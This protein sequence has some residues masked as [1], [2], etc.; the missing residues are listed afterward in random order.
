[1]PN[2]RKQ[3]LIWVSVYLF[4]LISLLTPLGILTISMMTIPVIVLFMIMRI[5][6]FIIYQL[7]M[8][9]VLLIFTVAWPPGIF[10]TLISLY[11][12]IGASAMG[13]FY[14][15][16][17][18][19]ASVIAIGT[20][21]FLGELLL[22]L[23]ISAGLGLNLIEQYSALIKQSLESTQPLWNVSNSATEMEQMAATMAQMVPMFMIIFALFYA[24]I[25]HAI[26]RKLLSR[27]E[28]A[29]PALKPFKDWMIPKSW[30]WF[31]VAALLLEVLLPMDP[32]SVL[33]VILLNL[34]P[35]LML[36]FSIQGLSFLYYVS[37]AKG[38]GHVL[39]AV[40][41]VLFVFLSYF[42]SFL[43]IIDT[44]FNLRGRIKK[45]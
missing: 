27:T 12:V 45:H 21:V 9:T 43:G 28:M 26:G 38:W 33:T 8:H 44:S 32:S 35:L 25:T 29:I 18:S 4:L 13:Y 2:I 19:A 14:K 37:D 1:M 5:K 22:V 10:M 42:L 23:V 30:G 16:K 20:V 31:Y 41:V 36:A 3:A 40:G 24:W 11:F 6:S 7:I 39:P 17:S 34:L 15:K